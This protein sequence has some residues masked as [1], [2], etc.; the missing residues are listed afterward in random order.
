MKWKVEILG[1]NHE[2]WI[3]TKSSR[4]QALCY[5][6]WSQWTGATLRFSNGTV[7]HM[8]PRHIRRFV[9]FQEDNSEV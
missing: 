9:V 1:T 8:S 3:T 7:E 5:V 6:Y 2:K 4:F